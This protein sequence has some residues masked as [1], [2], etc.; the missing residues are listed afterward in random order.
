MNHK[1]WNAVTRTGTAFLVLLMTF[2]IQTPI[3][4]QPFGRLSDSEIFEPPKSEDLDLGLVYDE[5][6]LERVIDPKEYVIGP[7]DEFS[8]FINLLESAIYPVKV[9]P[10]GNV[11][12][13]KIGTIPVS[14]LTLETAIETVK[15]ACLRIYIGA[16]IDVDLIK[17]RTF[18][19]LVSGAVK[20]P[21]FVE[22]T[23][24]NRVT[25]VIDKA[26]SLLKFAKK[27]EIMLIT[28]DGDSSI[29]NLIN[30]Y[31]DGDLTQNP[32][33]DIDMHVHVGFG[34]LE[35]NGV[36][37]RGAVLEQG[38]RMIGQDESLGDF[39]NRQVLLR[40][41]ADLSEVVVERQV[42]GVP[43]NNFVL[44]EDFFSFL[45]QPG[46]AVE[47]L[48]IRSV[49]VYGQ[50]GNP[51]S[52]EFIPGYDVGQYIDMAGGVLESGSSSKVSVIRTDGSMTSGL[53]LVVMR[54]DVIFVP[55][56]NRHIL[57]GELS[58]LE[59]LSAVASL[60]LTFV[61]ASAVF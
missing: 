16:R 7:G 41:Y 53:D 58:V 10:S 25:D 59:F 5:L 30:F 4:A 47:I 48:P 49:S 1:Y 12:I 61:A 15:K 32:N 29:L 54:G 20:D 31:S 43:E 33:L 22:C 34:N 24:V 57:I 18:L 60:F 11:I 51:G 27:H 19:V 6:A 45:L 55:F 36:V 2:A 56:S 8:V 50:V 39:V 38:Y 14:G 37:V 46:D 9:T 42:E 13:P 52:Y 3:H 28:A 21:G 40:D 23:P 26:G 44:T 17:I 35:R